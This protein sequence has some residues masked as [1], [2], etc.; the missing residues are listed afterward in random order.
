MAAIGI[1]FDE[2]SLVFTKEY[3]FYHS[4]KKKFD[5]LFNFQK[6]LKESL[7]DYVKRFKVENA[8]IVEC[9]NQIASAAFQKRLPKDHLLFGELIIGEDLTLEDLFDVAEK[10]ALWDEAQRFSI[11]IHHILHDIKSESWFKLL[12]QSKGDTSKLEHTK[13][14][15]FIE[16]PV[17]TDD[18]YTW[19][20]YLEKLVK[21]GKVDKYL[22]KLAV[23]PR[24]N[25]DAD[26]EPLTKT[27]R[28]NGIFHR[29]KDLG[30]TNNSKKRN[31]QQALL[32]S[33]VQDAKG[34]D[35][36]HD[37]ALVISVQL[38]NAIVD[39]MMVDNGSVVNLLQLSV[40][41]KKGLENTII[42]QAEVFT[43]FIGHTSTTIGNITL[44]VRIPPVV[45]K[46]IYPKIE[47]LILALAVAAR[48]LR[49]YFQA[50][51]VI[52]MTQYP[53]K[54]ILHGPDASQQ[55]IKWAL[56]LGQYGLVYRPRMVIKAQTLVDFITE[57]TPNLGDATEWPN[58]TP[59]A[60]EHAITMPASPDGDFWHLHVDAHPTT[61][62]LE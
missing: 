30:T 36:P 62:A 44:D 25:A 42:C 33:Q 18:C 11:P 49:P 29:S 55:V 24:R 4:I 26:E 27:I 20:S 52:V 7:Y 13:Y 17:T 8:K 53:L 15:T 46:Q 9:K 5:H 34:V 41:Q 2:L 56:E 28:T 10:H 22:D 12:K 39:R 59:K 48:K 16:V 6:N 51:T 1:S 32:V 58:D 40:I 47:K 3:S 37:H 35:F 61:R 14:C 50:H 43:R 54:S 38:A 19:R 60:T 57:F 31:I 23:R 21:E 45:S